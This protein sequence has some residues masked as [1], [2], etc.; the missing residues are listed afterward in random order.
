MPINAQILDNPKSD[1]V[2]RVADLARAKG[3]ER[4]GR[5]LIEGP[6]SVREAVTW[7]PDVVQDLYVEVAQA[8]D[9]PR[10]ASST[11]E[12]IVDTSQDATIYVH[13]CTGEVIRRISSD[14]QGIVAVGNANAI[15]WSVEDVDLGGAPQV[16]A[17]W[18]VRDPGNAGTVIRAADAAGCDAVVFVDDCVDMLN[19]K[20]IRSTVGSLFHL[21]VLTMGT[22]EFFAWTAAQ[23]M[24]VW[25][26]DVYGIPGREPESLPSV[27]ADPDAAGRP[28]TVLFGN[29][30]R[31]LEPGILARCGRIVSIP[32][33]GKAES[34]N[35]A[36]SAAVMLMSL[37]MSRHIETM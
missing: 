31:G 21:P 22:E 27:L 17:F 34:L 28:K 36:T 2:R 24:D 1:R 30:A 15:R 20:V 10:I 23:H 35:L 26:A 29:E 33:Y 12:K 19:P 32:L 16:A 11:L 5:F 4:S 7:R 3:R 14:A 8:L 18:Q 37:A 9:H 6:Q 25:A 13:R